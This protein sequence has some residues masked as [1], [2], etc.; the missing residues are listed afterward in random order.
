MTGHGF[1]EAIE[2]PPRPHYPCVLRLLRHYCPEK[3]ESVGQSARRANYLVSTLPP[4]GHDKCVMESD[5]QLHSHGCWLRP[6][7]NM[8]AATQPLFPMSCSL[9]WPSAPVFNIAAVQWERSSHSKLLSCPFK[10]DLFQ[11][12]FHFFNSSFFLSYIRLS[13]QHGSNTLVIFPPSTTTKL[14]HPSA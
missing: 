9:W 6:L 13:C 12:V 1:M 2:P 7:F 5:E 11:Q 3:R 8:T 14:P 10:Y 4:S